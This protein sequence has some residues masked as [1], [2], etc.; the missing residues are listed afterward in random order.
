L[1]DAIGELTDSVI[2][3]HRPYLEEM[4]AA[5]VIPPK[6]HRMYVNQGY[7]EEF[8]GN[9]APLARICWANPV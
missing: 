9:R 5:G 6:S 7:S 2:C 4:R 8:F 3:E 1:G